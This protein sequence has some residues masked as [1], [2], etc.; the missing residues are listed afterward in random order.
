LTAGAGVLV[1]TANPASALRRV[2]SRLLYRSDFARIVLKRGRRGMR[3][4]RAV[5][6]A[7][8]LGAEAMP[9][10]SA[11]IEVGGTTFVTSLSC[12]P[13]GGRRFT[14]RG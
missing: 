7:V 2:G 14:C 4:V 1:D 3:A 9:V 6:R 11:N 8:P 13:R 12:S 5:V 10:V